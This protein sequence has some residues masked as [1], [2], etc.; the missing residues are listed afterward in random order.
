MIFVDTNIFLRYI[1]KNV[2]AQSKQAK[3]ILEQVEMGKIEFWTT[4]WVIAE[5]IWTLS[6]RKYGFDRKKVYN[7]IRTFIGL[8]GLTVENGD[9][10]LEALKL[11]EEKSI[12]FTDCL[13]SI[14]SRQNEVS[15]VYSFDK[16][17]DKFPGLKRKKIS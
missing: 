7:F 17:F 14:L 10:I 13:N 15:Q 8:K 5:L 4:Q 6:L 9:L 2:P 16:H 1:L 3:Q 11:S 12:G